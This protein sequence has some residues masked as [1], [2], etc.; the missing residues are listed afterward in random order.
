MGV[1]S[2][3]L[4]EVL[5][6]P[7]YELFLD[8]DI[9]YY[10]RFKAL[11]IN[12]F[13]NREIAYDTV[14]YFRMRLNY[15]LSLNAPVYNKMLRSEM[16]EFDPFMTDYMETNTETNS[17]THEGT[18]EKTFEGSE[19]KRDSAKGH[20][21]NNNERYQGK[22]LEHTA[23]SLT[24]TDVNAELYSE[25]ENQAVDKKG[26]EHK[27][28]EDHTTGN[29]TSKENQK[30]TEITDTDY[31]SNVKADRTSN[32]DINR[33]QDRNQS[34]RQWTERGNDKRHGLNVDSNTPMAMLFNEPNHYYGTGTPHDYGKVVTDAEGNQDY[35]HY[36]EGDISFMDSQPRQINGGDTPWYNYATGANN[37]I[38]HG[39]YDK[40]GTETYRI[41]DTTNTGDEYEQHD[42]RDQTDNTHT[43]VEGTR[44][45]NY[46]EN[47]K[48]DVNGSHD[49]NTETNEL[50]SRTANSNAHSKGDRTE[51]TA[52]Q[53]DSQ[54][55]YKKVADLLSHESERAKELYS[56]DT[57]RSLD[58]GISSDTRSRSVKSG[59]TMKSPSKLLEEYRNVI[60]YSA[61]K[62]FLGELEKVFLQIF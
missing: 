52:G 24:G 2:K 21:S 16:V 39:N 19:R 48:E 42:T 9:L 54:N 5:A 55:Q 32:R 58:R 38:A 53:K 35:E 12:N 3:T 37:N 41:N 14:D 1:I 46:N 26:Q 22:D 57:T 62:W 30:Y 17:D 27:S 11:F 61:D 51:Q 28:Y 56:Q 23:G 18:R 43:E 50:N 20:H 13:Y 34:D 15:Y 33:V 60:T 25:A 10:D 49:V 31:T 59:R 36:G 7:G 40:S 8:Q 4:G 47:Y 45:I 6:L 29:V 44:D